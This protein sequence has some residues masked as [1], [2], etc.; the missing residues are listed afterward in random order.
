MHFFKKKLLPLLLALTVL[1]AAGCS[2]KIG[3]PDNSAKPSAS[4]KAT[5][6][7]SPSAM[8]SESPMTSPSGSPEASPDAS[9]DT[10]PD[11]SQ[12]ADAIP[13]FM[14]GEIVDPDDVPSLVALLAEHEGYRG[15]SIQSITYKLF[16]GR[17]AYYVILQGEGEASYPVYVFG[18]DTVVPAE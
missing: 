4:P 17:Q 1:L 8:A 3:E 18:D 14:E 12:E 9:P 15:M 6:E 2:K 5:A 13:G 7:T 16:E 11:A 10:S